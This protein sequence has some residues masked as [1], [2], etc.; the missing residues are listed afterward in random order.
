MQQPPNKLHYVSLIQLAQSVPR[1]HSLCLTQLPLWERRLTW[2]RLIL[3]ALTLLTVVAFNLSFVWGFPAL[4][5]L[6]LHALCGSS[7]SQPLAQWQRCQQTLERLG[8][9]VEALQKL[10]LSEVEVIAD[11]V[12]LKREETL[13]WRKEVGS[14]IEKLY[15]VN[16]VSISSPGLKVRL[17]DA[18][19][20]LERSGACP[21]YGAGSS[22]ETTA[23]SAVEIELSRT[24]PLGLERLRHRIYAHKAG[25]RPELYADSDRL[26]IVWSWEREATPGMLLEALAWF[27]LWSRTLD[28]PE[29][30]PCPGCDAELVEGS[31]PSCGGAGTGNPTRV[32][33][34]RAPSRRSQALPA[35]DRLMEI[36]HGLP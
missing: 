11:C 36:S 30:A 27:S 32:Q 28:R 15:Q 33:F 34:T 26:R 8:S 3:L 29:L 19:H 20:E 18:L 10:N 2:H 14:D 9:L 35:C 31:C 12:P 7:F 24:E 6:S 22:C 21:E 23:S 25:P 1:Q 4:L 17:I 5:V 13:I 16:W